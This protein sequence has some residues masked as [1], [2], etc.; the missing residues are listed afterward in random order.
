MAD[1]SRAEELVQTIE[2]DD[3]FRAEVEAAPTATAKRHLLDA[4]GYQDVTLDDM[5]AY[6]ES[7]GGTLVV[8]QG[9]RELSEQELAA[10]AGGLSS[11]ESA[12]IGYV[13]GV[14]AIGLGIAAAAG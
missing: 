13:A 4:H 6:V 2:R 12:A 3:A 9:G 11:E 8:P 7:K 14:A 5:R 1:L 10:V